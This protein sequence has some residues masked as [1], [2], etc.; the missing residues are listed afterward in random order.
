M[1]IYAVAAGFIGGC[2]AGFIGGAVA[3]WFSGWQYSA[4]LIEF[5]RKLNQFWGSFSSQKGVDARAENAAQE[6]ALLAQAM[7]IWQKDSPDKM[8]ELAA[9]AAQNPAMA[10]KIMKKLGISL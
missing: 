6:Q 4:K 5:E 2:F 3:G 8:K 9:L 10:M 7:A 1:D